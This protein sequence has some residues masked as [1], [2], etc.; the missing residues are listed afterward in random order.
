LVYVV[1]GATS[2]VGT[3]IAVYGLWAATEGA[4]EGILQAACTWVFR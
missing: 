1:V 3:A 4:G 2:V